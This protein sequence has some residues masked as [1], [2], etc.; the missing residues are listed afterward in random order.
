MTQGGLRLFRRFKR[1]TRGK[2]FAKL[3]HRMEPDD[4]G[5]DCL[6]LHIYYNNPDSMEG[7]KIDLM[8]DAQLY[9]RVYDHITARVFDEDVV[10]ALRQRG[11]LMDIIAPPNEP[12]R[13]AD[14][15]LEPFLA[16]TSVH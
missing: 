11:R 6:A 13:L 2:V 8:P 7:I 14:A 5:K 4:S 3:V 10:S 12:P 15:D 16:S 1:D 9:A